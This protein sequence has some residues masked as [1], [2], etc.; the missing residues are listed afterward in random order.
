MQLITDLIIAI[1]AGI[2]IWA[3]VISVQDPVTT[4]TVRAVPVNLLNEESIAASGLA[5][6]GTGEYTVDVVVGGTR[7]N[8]SKVSAADFT[9]SADVSD[10]HI[11]QN[12]INV[13][14][15][16]PSNLTVNEIRTQSIQ[17][18]VDTLVSAAKPL[19]IDTIN[20]GASQELG[21]IS[22]SAEQFTV[23]GAE[24]LVD[25]VVALRAEIDAKDIKID[26]EFSQSV[27]LQPVD[28]D[29]H[30]VAGVKINQSSIK[31]TA[32]LYETKEVA[33]AVPLIGDFSD[34]IKMLSELIP[35]SVV[36]KGPMHELAD[37]WTVDAEAVYRNQISESCSIPISVICPD[38]IELAKAS[39][40]LY[41]VYEV[42]G[43][44]SEEYIF[45]NESVIYFVNVPEGVTPSLTED[46]VVTAS[47][48]EDAEGLVDESDIIISIDCSEYTS[49]IHSC[50]VDVAVSVEIE[51][52][53]VSLAKSSVGVRFSSEE[54]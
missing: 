53:N 20:K 2:V 6:A 40:E 46:I 10:L 14:V 45:S 26:E 19:R 1:I 33:L 44:V 35:S 42:I 47:V 11:G 41:A 31:I 17:V 39:E 51:G 54:E 34:D 49:G 15:E 50:P 23:S 32:T 13:K 22:L 43:R 27:R 5:I 52:L 36:I 4:A 18:Y 30:A 3:Y 24:S 25:N 9:A 12:Y 37:I 16:A 8:V 38:G 21:N 48:Y 7:S 29:G 28:S